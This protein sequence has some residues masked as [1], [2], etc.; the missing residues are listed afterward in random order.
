MFAR[1]LATML[2]LLLW[3]AASVAQTPVPAKPAAKPAAKAPA[4]P[5][6]P[7]APTLPPASAEQI[8]TAEFAHYGEYQCEF[9]EVV[10]VERTPKFEGYV[11]VKHRKITATMK[12]VLSSTGAVRLEDVKGRLL[13]LQIASKSMLMDTKLGQRLVDN[14]VHEMQREAAAKPPLPSLGIEPPKEEAK[15]P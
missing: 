2:M 14:C 13:M 11:D 10:M 9:G 5:A 12:P 7:P 3:S 8:A 4:K 15:K 1:A 6:P